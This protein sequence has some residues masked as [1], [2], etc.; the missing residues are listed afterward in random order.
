M[1]HS[2]F[3][4]WSHH[5]FVNCFITLNNY[6]IIN[7]F[8]LFGMLCCIQTWLVNIMFTTRP[9]VWR[10]FWGW[11]GPWLPPTPSWQCD[12]PVPEY[13]RCV[14]CPFQHAPLPGTSSCPNLRTECLILN[15]NFVTGE[16]G[17]SRLQNLDFR[18]LTLTFYGKNGVLRWKWPQKKTLILNWTLI[19]ATLV[20][21]KYTKQAYFIKDDIYF[22]S[23]RFPCSQNKNVFLIRCY[24]YLSNA[25]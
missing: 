7:L 16:T 10:R 1:V 19:R 14:L 9:K 11:K 22:E 25:S 20:I 15:S 6:L 8:T 21:I 5:F 17:Y 23:L 4:K 3:S 2:N 18:D 24:E 13:Q 12:Y